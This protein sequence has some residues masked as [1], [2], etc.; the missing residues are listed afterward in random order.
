MLKTEKCFKPYR[1][2]L[3]YG[4]FISASS[5]VLT[6]V[7]TEIWKHNNSATNWDNRATNASIQTVI[8]VVNRPGLL[9]REHKEGQ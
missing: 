1:R 9:G 4:F 2:N 6:K 8:Q 5:T 7:I 3:F